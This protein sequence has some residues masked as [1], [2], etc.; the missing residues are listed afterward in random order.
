MKPGVVS[1]RRPGDRVRREPGA[2][3]TSKSAAGPPG[4]VLAPQAKSTRVS[5]S[6]QSLP[7]TQ[8]AARTVARHLVRSMSRVSA[9]SPRRR[10]LVPRS[11]ETVPLWST[12]SAP[13]HTR[14]SG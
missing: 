3:C 13:S 2:S 6:T 8:A 9:I 4:S 1:S 14:R 7:R 12:S 11:A 10:C 5:A